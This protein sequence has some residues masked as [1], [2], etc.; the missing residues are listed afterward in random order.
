MLIDTKMLHYLI[1][2][3]VIKANYLKNKKIVKSKIIF[4]YWILTLIRAII[5]SV[6]LILVINII[7]IVSFFWD[8]LFIDF[9]FFKL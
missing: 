9:S 4:K 3:I 7:W 8:L 1:P 5:E 2:F 6:G